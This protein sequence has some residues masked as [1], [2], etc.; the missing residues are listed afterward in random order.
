MLHPNLAINR[1]GHLTI[2]GVDTVTLAEKYGTPLYILD[3]DVIRS[4]CR[5]YVNSMKEY[6]GG[7]SV[8]LY[9]SKALSFKGIYTIA[10]EEG[11]CIDV[12]SPGEIY[13][14]LQAGFPASRM[15]FH[16]NNK[17]V[18]DIR[19]AIDNG[20]GHF[21]VDND[22]ELCDIDAIA[23]EAGVRQ[24][25]LVRIT[26]GIDPHT[27]AAVNT[28]KIDCQFGIPLATGQAL[29]FVGEVL[30]KE[31][32]N[33]RGFHCH[34]GSQIF[35]EVPFCDATDLMLDFISDVRDTYGYTAEVLNLGGGFGVRYVES[36]PSIDIAT[37]IQK[38][39]VHV[40][41]KCEEHKL[42]A[43]DI[44]MEPGR[45]IVADAGITIYSVGGTKTIE[46][47]KNYVSVDGGMTDNPRYALYG[48]AYTLMLAN[49]ADA[50]ADY[51]CTVAGR[52]CESGAL[53]QEN[54]L[55]P[56]PVAGDLLAVFVT[57]AYNHSMSS[58]YNRICRPPI[59]MVAG[60]H[61]RLV[62]RRETFEDLV[63][64]DL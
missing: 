11:M 41:T 52:C 27:F 8:P 15:Y 57:G 30:K 21:I 54:V 59:V 25:V 62:V 19:Y 32:I 29:P 2:G 22:R 46:G 36:D 58:N 49:K 34:I 35:D 53:I 10:A 60:G 61:D 12:V 28:G 64:R 43:L 13:T 20:V 6:F 55:L 45:S 14:A 23:A 26:P 51:L 50:P 39:S 47:Y 5:T 40:K 1:Q 31:H 56:K 9:A 16:G 7:N 33:L 38:L 37:C 63:A 24:D 17:T 18:D 44:L 42:P 48:S 4:K 3:E